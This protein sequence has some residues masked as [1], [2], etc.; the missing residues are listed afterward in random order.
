MAADA[1]PPTLKELRRSLRRAIDA[2]GAYAEDEHPS[3]A[4]TREQVQHLTAQVTTLI[5]L[6]LG[7]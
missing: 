4:A 5:R 2:N 6:V 3:A 1:P 7:E